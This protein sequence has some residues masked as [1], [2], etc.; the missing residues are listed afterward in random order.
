M[1]KRRSQARRSFYPRAQFK[2]IVVLFP[3][4]VAIAKK[5]GVSI[6]EYAKHLKT[7]YTRK[8]YI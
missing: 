1:M 5:L 8:E 3:T 2:R 6:E 4:E 7:T